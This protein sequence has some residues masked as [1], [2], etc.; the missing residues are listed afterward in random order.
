MN[1]TSK[2][3]TFEIERYARK[4]IKHECSVRIENSIP[5]DRCFASLGKASWCK[6]VTLGTEFSIRTSHPCKI[7]IFYPNQKP[8][9]SLSGVQEN[10][11]VLLKSGKSTT[12]ERINKNVI[13]VVFDWSHTCTC[14][15]LKKM[16]LITRKFVLI[17]MNLFE[18]CV[19]LRKRQFYSYLIHPYF[20]YMCVP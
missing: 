20:Y 10:M 1:A 8:W 4:R 17:Y 9:I 11:I 19:Y 15:H 7:L 18:L 2:N 14:T 6:T 12:I 16:C 5:R 13:E 3:K